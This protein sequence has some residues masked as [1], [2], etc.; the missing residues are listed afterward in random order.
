MC[1]EEENQFCYHGL[2]VKGVGNGNYTV[3]LEGRRVCY[4]DKSRGRDFDIGLPDEGLAR[5][6]E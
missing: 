6:V 4:R 1:N 5:E 3:S 2:A